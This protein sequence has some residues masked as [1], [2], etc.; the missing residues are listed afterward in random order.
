MPKMSIYK[1]RLIQGKCTFT[2]RNVTF[3]MNKVAYKL[4]QI[5]SNDFCKPTLGINKR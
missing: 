1:G 4:L 2:R 5:T 3:K